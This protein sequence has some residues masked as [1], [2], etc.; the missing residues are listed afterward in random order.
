MNTCFEP[1]QRG[2]ERVSKKTQGTRD[3]SQKT[4]HPRPFLRAFTITE[5]LVV[6]GIIILLIGLLL[7]ALGR[8]RQKARVTQTSS[9]L[10]EF[11][12]ACDAFNQQF[13]YY[14]GVV[15][16]YI[17]ENDPKITAT[18]N[19]ILHMTGG[20]V[21]AD[22]LP[23]WINGDPYNNLSDIASQIGGEV[24]T[25]TAPDGSGFDVLIDARNVGE[26]PFVEG[27]RYAPFYAPKGSELAAAQGVFR[28]GASE[29]ELQFIPSVLDAWG[30]PILYARRIRSNGPLAGSAD[31]TSSGDY[32]AGAQF[33]FPVH[34]TLLASD[35]LG[36]LNQEQP[37]DGGEG[38]I[39]G[40]NDSSRN[41][42]NFAQI[43]RTPAIGSAKQPLSGAP[44]GEYIVISAGPDGVFFDSV[45]GP[46]NIDTPI[47]NI[48]DHNV[49]GT[50]TVVSEYDDIIVSGGG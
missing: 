22:E 47:T 15:P 30:T 31:H 9:T 35:G 29:D 21:R 13:G 32:E 5:L 44:R 2:G 17:L 7:P 18:E 48:H 11:A 23:I 16:E 38:S 25:F 45:D 28:D 27:K 36:I 49:F 24:I 3:M 4:R 34:Q 41:A 42:L 46:G 33:S 14:P 10:E 26:G 12:K 43:L 1:P 50:P 37:Y 8:V 40:T 19:A 39:L 6:V 20:A